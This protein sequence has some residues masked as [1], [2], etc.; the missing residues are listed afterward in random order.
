MAFKF[1]KTSLLIPLNVNEKVFKIRKKNLIELIPRKTI[2][3]K[4]LKELC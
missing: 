1:N 4:N 3:R 2:N